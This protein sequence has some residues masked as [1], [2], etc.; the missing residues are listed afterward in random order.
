MANK[1]PFLIS[2]SGSHISRSAFRRMRKA[3]KLELMI[4]W[5]EENFENP[6]ERT[7]YES[8]EGGYH[9]IWGGPYE[10]R[11]ELYSMFGD[12]VPE[13]LIEEAVEKVE[14]EGVT[15]WA[16]TPDREDY[17][18][19]EPLDEDPLPLTIFENERSSAY[20]SAEE[21]A[22]RAQALKAV[23]LLRKVLDQPLPIGIGHN[24][25]PPDEDDIKDLRPAMD[26][27]HEELAK[28]E[29][30]IQNVKKWAEPLRNAVIASI[31]WIAKKVD[32]AADAAAAA[33]G[34]AL[35]AYYSEPLK[36]TLDAVI[37]WLLI[38]ASTVF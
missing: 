32:K 27:L 29:P 1:R 2:D 11:D 36:N 4:E 8:R 21:L 19:S 33:G 22:A 18:E 35:V 26:E 28:P 14:E 34:L 17:D 24:K 7:P 38:A 30:E 15:E 13:A 6:A 20:G 37:K 5:F 3:E 12:L 25:P 31:K 9:W 10:A 23:D 16:P